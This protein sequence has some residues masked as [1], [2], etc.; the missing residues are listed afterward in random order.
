[1][2]V[3][4]SMRE[5]KN[6]GSIGGAILAAVIVYVTMQIK[7]INQTRKYQHDLKDLNVRMADKL[8]N[9]EDRYTGAEKL[10]EAAH[11]IKSRLATLHLVRN[12]AQRSLEEFRQAQE[13]GAHD[14]AFFNNYGVALARAGNK[15]QAVEC[16]EQAAVRL[17][18][19]ADPHMNLAHAV[20]P[21]EIWKDG[22]A[23]R[24]ALEH[25]KRAL[26]IGG[27]SF[28]ILEREGIV[29]LQGGRYE[30]ARVEFNRALDVAG[31]SKRC[32]ADARNHLGIDH[33][34]AEE[35]RE[36]LEEFKAAMALDKGHA[37][38]LCNSGIVQTLQ[39][40]MFLGLE[41]ILQSRELE[42]K[43]PVILNNLGYA[44][45]VS[46]S[47]NDG[48]SSF[49]GA[50]SN[51]AL[52]WEAYYNLGKLY[53][54]E[55]FYEFAERHLERALDL[56]PLTW[57]ALVALGVA[58]L[59][60]DEHFAAAEILRKA[61][62]LAPD[63]SPVLTNLGIA[64]AFVFEY[65]EAERLL[66][67]A[68]A[69]TQNDPLPWARLAWMHVMQG[70]PRFAAEELKTALKIAPKDPIYNNYFG[71]VNLDLGAT[72]VAMLYFKRALGYKSDYGAVHYHIGYV[73][74]IRKSLPDAIKEWEKTTHAE[75]EFADGFVNLGVAYYEVQRLEDAVQSFRKALVIRQNRMEDYANLALTY[76]KQ[77]VVLRK[78]SKP[79]DRR[80]KS[81][82]EKFR[83]AIEMFDKALAMEPQNVVLHSNRGLACWYA[84]DVD[85]ACVEWTLVSHIDP[86][87][88][89][90][91]GELMRSAFDETS[92]SYAPIRI[93]DRMFGFP[94]IT[95]NYRYR[96][97]PGYDA[98]NW[99]L[100]IEDEELAEVP[101]L[102]REV[103]FIERNLRGL[104]V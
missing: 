90:R 41:A 74:L 86:E 99:N 77:G 76:S 31:G 55:G 5:Y 39:N 70:V 80:S 72:D 104:H 78:D 95:A 57:E 36:A 87:Y 37:R 48:I 67:R 83:L 11:L 38:A 21:T 93:S 84:E 96:V 59:R 27:G 88:A 8:D 25:V 33:W 10:G 58:K 69:G 101:E 23:S 52:M 92:L 61:Y 13:G 75:P 34:L 51:D 18:D 79:G 85:E 29:L 49:K 40:K 45:C 14:A 35:Y 26:E 54:D 62:E 20:A 44:L 3:A 89:A 103:S 1:M 50:I 98:D 46:G 4:P 56:R 102:A 94:L 60:Q 2:N 97:A 53:V 16:L 47:C 82:V 73:Y 64:L 91:R 66:R 30:D 6:Y 100:M 24:A 63:E 9:A 12:E 65:E 15:N 32:E 42:P 71:L 28:E 43:N 22:A 19:S 17:T 7:L 81:A 68:L